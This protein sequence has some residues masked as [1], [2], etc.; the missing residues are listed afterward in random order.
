MI[1]AYIPPQFL[2]D[3]IVKAGVISLLF[4]YAIVW[5]PSIMIR[6]E[7]QREKGAPL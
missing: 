7:I 2:I 4:I 6:F 3:A 5:G 1:V